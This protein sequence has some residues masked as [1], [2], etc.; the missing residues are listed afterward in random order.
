MRILSRFFF[1]AAI[2][3]AALASCTPASTGNTGF[4]PATHLTRPLDS[5]GGLPPKPAPTR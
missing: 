3:S 1:A 4:I 5:G 2:L